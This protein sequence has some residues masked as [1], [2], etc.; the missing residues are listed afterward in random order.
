MTKHFELY[1]DGACSGNPGRGGFSAIIFDEDRRVCDVTGGYR[2]TTNNRMEILAVAK[3]LRKLHAITNRSSRDTD[4]KVTVYSDSQL[5][6]NTMTQGWAR[7]TNSDLWRE[8]DDA[9][10]LFDGVIVNF[11]KVKG[12]STNPKNNLADQMAVAASQ[13]VNAVQVDEYYEHIATEARI[14]PLETEA[15]P[16]VTDIKLENVH[17]TT[18][19]KVRVSLSN[20]N[21]VVILPLLGGFEQTGCT[22]AEAFITIDIAHRFTEWLNGKEL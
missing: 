11:V 3:G 7:K 9:L 5:V 18:G 16:V 14:L 4:I 8:L 20:G 1:T 15:E 6:V 17:Q 13:P 21:E 2:L 12:H 10:S 19:R 22:Q